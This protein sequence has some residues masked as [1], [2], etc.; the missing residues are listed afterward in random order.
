MND[1]N[2][3]HAPQLIPQPSDLAGNYDLIQQINQ[4]SE[5][6]ELNNPIAEVNNQNECL[7]NNTLQFWQSLADQESAYYRGLFF[8]TNQTSSSLKGNAYVNRQQNTGNL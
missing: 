1:Q 3:Q 2:Q 7:P 8:Q 5:E 4:G 6:T